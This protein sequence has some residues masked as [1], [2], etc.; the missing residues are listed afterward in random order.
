VEAEG[1]RKQRI[2]NLQSE[3]Y[4]EDQRDAENKIL[5]P[6]QASNYLF[7]EG[8][9]CNLQKDINLLDKL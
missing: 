9:N 1:Q 2:K 4:E 6:V 5:R 7:S 3:E 8:K